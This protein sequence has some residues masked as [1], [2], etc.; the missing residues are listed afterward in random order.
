MTGDG[1]KQRQKEAAVRNGIAAYR[2]T[3]MAFR[4]FRPKAYLNPKTKM[5]YIAICQSKDVVAS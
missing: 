1:R 5:Y 3:I 4:Q 2:E